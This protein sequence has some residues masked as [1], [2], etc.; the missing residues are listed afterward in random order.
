MVYISINFLAFHLN[1]L[2]VWWWYSGSIWHYYLAYSLHFHC[3]C[4]VNLFWEHLQNKRY[5]KCHCS[6]EC[7][8]IFKDWSPQKA[9]V[10][11]QICELESYILFRWFIRSLFHLIGNQWFLMSVNKLRLKDEKFARKRINIVIYYNIGAP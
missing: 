7:H 11:N 8:I 6:F 1:R 10:S 4:V 9:K 3:R 2:S 5:A